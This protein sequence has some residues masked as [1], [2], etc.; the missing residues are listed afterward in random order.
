MLNR[1]APDSVRSR[2]ASMA[3]PPPSNGNDRPLFY[4]LSRPSA[5]GR[6]EDNVF[7]DD[8]TLWV[9]DHLTPRRFT[10]VPGREW[11]CFVELAQ[12]TSST[13]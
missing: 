11:V 5:S 2:S 6:T 12:L 4:R 9:S 3:H 13:A 7:P 10:I 8:E 1:L